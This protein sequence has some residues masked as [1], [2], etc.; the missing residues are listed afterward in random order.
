[1]RGP[2]PLSDSDFA[3]VRAAV[4]SRIE[5][6]RT[7]PAWYVALAASVAVAVLSSVVARQPLTAPSASR[8]VVIARAAR[9]TPTPILRSAQDDRRVA[10]HRKHTKT[11]VARIELH[12]AD[13]NIRII[14]ITN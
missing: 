10:H 6:R 8:H 9:P 5:R 7:S 14:W 12:T 4:L 13:P 3:A 1:M 11:Q 2:L